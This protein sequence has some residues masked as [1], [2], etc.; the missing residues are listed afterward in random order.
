MAK[1]HFKVKWRSSG[2]REVFVH[3]KIEIMKQFFLPH[4]S[5]VFVR[6][7]RK[8]SGRA[9]GSTLSTSAK[10]EHQRLGV[11]MNSCHVS[12]AFLMK[13]KK[14]ATGSG[15]DDGMDPRFM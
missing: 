12:E 13:G 15:T 9:L 3:D 7:A 8:G 14:S 4:Y 5:P 11:M 10:I 1:Q 2:I 6:I